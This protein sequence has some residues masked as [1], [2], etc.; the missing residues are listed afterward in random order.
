MGANGSSE[1]DDFG[2]GRSRYGV[3][4]LPTGKPSPPEGIPK[5]KD[6]THNSITLSW[7]SPMNSGKILAYQV[8]SCTTKDKK[9]K[10]HTSTCQ[11]TCYH[12]RN[13]NPETRY[14]FR[15]RAENILGQSKPGYSS[16]QIITRPIP[17]NYLEEKPTKKLVRRHSHYLKIDHGVNA[18]LSRTGNEEDNN[19][20]VGAIPFRRNNSL[21]GSLP[22]TLRSKRNSVTLLLPGSKRENVCNY[23][24]SKRSIDESLVT[25]EDGLN[26]KRISTSSTEASSIFSSNSMTS[27]AEAD[28]LQ[29]VMY[30]HT[31]CHMC[32][33]NDDSYSTTASSQYSSSSSRSS[34]S[35]HCTHNSSNIHDNAHLNFVS[36]SE[37]VRRDLNYTDSSDQ[38]DGFNRNVSSFKPRAIHC[39]NNHNT[40]NNSIGK[41]IFEICDNEI[42]KGRIDHDNKNRNT[43]LQRNNSYRGNKNTL[44]LRSIR[45]MLTSEDVMVKT[46]D[47]RNLNNIKRTPSAITELDEECVTMDIVSTI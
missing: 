34:H 42:W 40:T 37:Q 46:L 23:K 35:S 1:V 41:T 8:E 25:E 12:V 27:I 4:N 9:W 36:S 16:E 32:S 7:L 14:I 33:D 29:Q 47:S 21:R 20:D 3:S 31:D 11:G 13:L 45:Q 18:L 30:E 10:I 39:H 15:V 2:L 28:E 38:T 6:I 44:D 5:I 24:E 26:L 43:D 19:T 17:T 22:S